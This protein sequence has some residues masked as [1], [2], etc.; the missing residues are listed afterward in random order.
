[1]PSAAESIT[2]RANGQK[3][4]PSWF[5]ALRTAIINDFGGSSSYGIAA[6]VNANALTIALKTSGGDDA[7]GDSPIN[8]TFRSATATTGTPVT[9]TV[10]AAL[11][12][13]V[14]S[15]STLGHT[16][17][18]DEYVHVYAI[19]NAGTVEL[20][21]SNWN[22]FDEGSLHSTTAEG[23]AGA[24]DD[25]YTLYSTTART[26]VAI[27]YLCRI[28]SNQAAAGTWATAPSEITVASTLRSPICF[29]Q[30]N[31]NAGQLI[32]SGSTTVVNYDTKLFDSHGLVTTGAAW[33]FTADRRMLA[34]VSA[35][36]TTV[37]NIYDAGEYFHLLV[38]VNGTML[39]TLN[40]VSVDSSTA[41]RRGA[42]GT[43]SV[44]LNAG[45]YVDA[46]VNQN[47]GSNAAL[48]NYYY[49]RIAIIGIYL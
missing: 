1:M 5:N 44:I 22:G 37:T 7:S 40:H 28:K 18:K 33:K 24:A 11:S 48:D 13:T 46:S 17:G 49:N 19:D 39:T 12:G 34:I 31:T 16:S 14:S 43:H 9:R 42:S 36:A 3:I 32:P 26:D 2:L 47:G 8:L 4:L 15:G 30:Y 10:T 25:G 6:S 41:V 38:R 35:S 29:A 23:G 27:K 45:D 21:W 20:A